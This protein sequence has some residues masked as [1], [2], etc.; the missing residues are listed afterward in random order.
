FEPPVPE[1]FRV[2]RRNDDRR[3]R[4][5]TAC[6]IRLI[7]ATAD[8]IACVTL[9]GLAGPIRLVEVLVRR[10]AGDAMILDAGMGTDALRILK[11]FEVL[12]IEIETDV[13]V[14]FPIVEVRWIADAFAPYQLR[15]HRMPGERRH[16]GRAG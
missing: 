1:E 11:R 12:M 5:A 16:A 10:R 9:G 7:A 14:I 3:H 2:I 13:T 6:P 4:H 8:E 15:G